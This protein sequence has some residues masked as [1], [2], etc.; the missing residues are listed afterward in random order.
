L[1]LI[2]DILDLSKVEA[3]KIT[4]EYAPVNL[5]SLC[6]ASLRMVVEQAHKKHLQ[7]SLELAP[8]P[9]TILADER[10]LK[11]A[12]VNLLSNAVKFTPVEGKVGLEV[13]PDK[14]NQNLLMTVWDTGIGIAAKDQAYL[15]KPFVQL[16]SGLTREYSGTGLGLALVAEMTRLH[17]GSVSLESEPGKGS[18]FTMRLPLLNEE[19]K[20]ANTKEITSPASSEKIV[21]PGKMV[22]VLV[23]ED[24]PTSAMVVNDYLEAIGHRV[25]LAPNGMEAITLAKKEQPD[26]IL[27][28]VQMPVMD[29]LEASQKIHAEA[30]LEQVP[31]IAL[32]ALA[33]PGD[34][35]RCLQAG[36]QG[37]L[38]KPFM[39]KELDQVLEQYL[40]TKGKTDL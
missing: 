35:E 18:R 28:D 15:F 11:Q 30:G 7:L 16:D 26:L 22:T 32:T 29:G 38:T 23:V 27:M 31:I 34:R 2:N 13:R 25:I 4:L 39:L 36:M 10:R 19:G 6:E 17:G 12:V 1:S 9:A 40:H 37:Y 20:P 33:M 14:D 8:E 21:K 5:K 24:T 3:G